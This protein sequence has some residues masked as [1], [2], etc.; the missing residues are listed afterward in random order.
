MPRIRVFINTIAN[1]GY[2]NKELE[3]LDAELGQQYCRLQFKQTKDSITSALDMATPELLLELTQ[4]LN[5]EFLC[6]SD[7]Q[8]LAHVLQGFAKSKAQPPELLKFLFNVYKT[9]RGDF[10]AFEKMLDSRVPMRNFKNAFK[11]LWPLHL[12]CK[13]FFALICL[14]DR[15]IS[16][17]LH[18]KFSD[19]LVQT[20]SDY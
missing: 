6:R 2:R 10:V 7:S 8:R 4:E 14:A 17:S 3:N 19:I 1:Q 20:A 15:K 18:T 16:R 11:M 13:L 12:L 5:Q 9:Q